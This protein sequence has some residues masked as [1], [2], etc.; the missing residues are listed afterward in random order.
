MTSHTP[1]DG[2]ARHFRGGAN[3]PGRFGR[4]NATWPFATLKLEAG[5]ICISVKPRLFGPRSLELSKS[6]PHRLFPVRGPLMRTPGVGVTVDGID[7]YFWTRKV[8]DVL[9]ALRQLGFEVETE[10][11][12][13]KTMTGRGRS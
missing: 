8:G 4:V 13:A 2:T 3:V 12:K 6:T 5:L 7:W 9:A 1:G 10:T 11:R